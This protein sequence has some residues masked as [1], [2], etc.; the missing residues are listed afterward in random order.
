[1]DDTGIWS[2]LQFG[3]ADLS[4]LKSNLSM[5]ISALDVFISSVIMRSITALRAMEPTLQKIYHTLN[6]NA[7]AI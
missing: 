2:R 4:K 6:D 1:M 5:Q 3:Q 7:R